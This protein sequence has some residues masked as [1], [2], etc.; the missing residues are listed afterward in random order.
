MAF[1]LAPYGIR[2]NC[3]CPGYTATPMQER[4]IVWEAAL[5]G[6]SEK[7]V[8]DGY[9]AN[10]P[11]GRIESPEDVARTIA[12]LLGPDSVFI[13]G[14]ALNVNGGVFMD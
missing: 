10:T 8:F 13:T 2:V 11:L 7:E 4:E 12:F 1:E 9:V 14:E 5:R 6:I 3:V